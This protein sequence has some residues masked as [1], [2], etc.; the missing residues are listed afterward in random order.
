[1]GRSLFRKRVSD[2]AERV[3]DRASAP[4]DGWGRE[5]TGVS[6]DDVLAWLD[7]PPDFTAPDSDAGAYRNSRTFE[8]DE[9]ADAADEARWAAYMAQD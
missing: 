2:A 8:V 6:D 5:D 4:G 9:V 1:M 7:L 3:R